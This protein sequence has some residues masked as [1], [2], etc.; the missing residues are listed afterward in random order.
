MRIT[1]E[2]G[3]VYEIRR[4][5]CRK[6]NSRGDHLDSFKP[7]TTKAVPDGVATLD[8]LHALEAGEPQ[9]GKR[10]YIA[11]ISGWWISTPVVSIE[12]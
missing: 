1:T 6:Y 5:I 12:K 8:E 2:S 7:I 11:G 4:G 3:S 10:L 9:V